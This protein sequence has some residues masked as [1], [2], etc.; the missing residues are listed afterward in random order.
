LINNIE[1][2]DGQGDLIEANKIIIGKEA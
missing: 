2:R 1:E